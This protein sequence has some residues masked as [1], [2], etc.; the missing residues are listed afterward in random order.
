M[1]Y[2]YLLLLLA[3]FSIT[4]SAHAQTDTLRHEILMETDSGN[5][6]IALY[7]ETPLHRDNMLKLVRSHAYDGMLFHRVIKDFMVQTGD[8]GSKNA[9]PGKL[10]GGTPEKYSIPAEIRFPQLYHKRGAVAAA[11]ESDDIN[12]N[13]VSSASQF[14][15]VCG[16]KYADNQ[17]DWVQGQLD[18][19]TDSTAKLTP[20]LR[21]VYK[22]IGGTP[23]LD[24]QY[25]VFGEVVEGMDVVSKI[26]HA[27]CDGND[28]PVAD[29]RVQ[30]VTVV[31]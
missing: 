25:T 26:E 11:R 12:P 8:L 13:K 19:A 29:I 5:I 18:A 22:T 17:L 2:R 31:K 27:S 28:R 9:A 30:R 4:I 20:E 15:I 23:F 24:A 6:R 3:I 16:H 1:R 21:E 14:Y 10:L 7:N